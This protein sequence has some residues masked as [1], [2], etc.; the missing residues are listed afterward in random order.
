MHELYDL[1]DQLM[2]ELKEYGKKGEL[3]AVSLDV[4]DK[5]THTIKNLC[6]II[7]EYEDQGYSGTDNRRY[8]RSEYDGSM[9]S[10]ARQGRGRNARRDSMGRYSGNGYSYDNDEMIEQLNA[11]MME[12]P[13]EVRKDIQ[14][15]IKKVESM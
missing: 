9:R 12:A 7:E 2:D 11:L 1:K 10:Y 3:S 8:S 13:E 5:L 15:V 14:K 6:K 4:M